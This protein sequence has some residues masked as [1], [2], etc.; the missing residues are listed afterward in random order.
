[1][2]EW[3][4][5]HKAVQHMVRRFVQQEIKPRLEEL[6]HGDTPPYD[7]LRKMMKTFGMDEM[8]KASFESQ[9]A[10]ERESEREMEDFRSEAFAA[11]FSGA[12]VFA[13][14]GLAGRETSIA[15]MAPKSA[16]PRPP[17]CWARHP[18]CRT[19][20]APSGATHNE[21]PT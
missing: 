1:M 19:S 15:A 4:E 7:V 18:R 21:V 3:S 6:E 8:R 20:S 12:N 5:Q 2:I 16:R 9:I 13:A 11:G 10:R 17:R 14:V